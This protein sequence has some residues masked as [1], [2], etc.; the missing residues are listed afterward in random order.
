MSPFP[1]L[2]IVEDHVMFC[3]CLAKGFR[4][5][6]DIVGVAHTCLE[7]LQLAAS[8]WPNIFLLDLALG[9][10]SGFELVPQIKQR[11]PG[12]RIV[13][14]T[15]YNN[16]GFHAK[17]RALEVEG[18]VSKTEPLTSLRETIRIVLSGGTRFTRADDGIGQNAVTAKLSV[19]LTKRQCDVLRELA[20]G[21]SYK[22][23]ALVTGLTENTVDIYLRRMRG[24]F[25]ARNS[26]DL[27]DLARQHGFL[28]SEPK[29]TDLAVL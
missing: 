23:I 22:E 18:F 20:R 2:V 28:L 16:E 11:A 21:L 6:Y 8:L 3:E 7:A 13:I 24:V 4:D 14:V 12:S 26:V 17:A 29:D 25:H 19:S 27:V 9:R 10:E 15:N 1:R 5:D